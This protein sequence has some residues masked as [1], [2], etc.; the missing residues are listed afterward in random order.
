MVVDTSVVIAA[1]TTRV[2]DSP[3]RRFLHAA[4]D[5]TVRT[6]LSDAFLAE[7]SEVVHRKDHEGLIVGASLAFDAAMHLWTHGSL[8][9]PTR[10]DWPSVDD[11]KD[12]WVLDLAWDAHA[13][14][15]VSL[16]AHLTKATIPFPVEV[17]EPDQLL[18]RL[19]S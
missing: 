12:H 4:G 7:L 6:A 14:F 16:D 15:I 5:G 18:A 2:E 3:N 10:M 17:V 11:R 13:D 19:L 8:Y 9:R 1:L